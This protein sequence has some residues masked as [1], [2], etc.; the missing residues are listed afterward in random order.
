[1]HCEQARQW[2]SRFQ[3]GELAPAMHAALADHLKICTA[4]A[5]ELASLTDLRRLVQAAGEPEPP[6]D[7]WERIS[8]QLPDPARPRSRWRQ[9]GRTVVAAGVL[10]VVL[11]AGGLGLRQAFHSAQPL[12]AAAGLPPA[13]QPYLDSRQLSHVGDP[14][15]LDQ[16]ARFVSFRVPADLSLPEDYQLEDCCV[17]GDGCCDV[18]CCCF[19]GRTDQV[20]LVL[21]ADGHPVRTN[22]PPL[23]QPRI[24]GKSVR[25]VR[26]AD[27]L[28]A[29]WQANGTAVSLIGPRDLDQLVQLA[30]YVDQRLQAEP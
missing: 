28:A 17:C 15:R 25:V 20:L 5:A 30:R 6:G 1:M 13:W 16:A 26:C 21:C 11:V 3:D 9:P 19:V 23:A 24:N 8:Q 14:V 2:L 4:C 10:L 22:G 29:L 18:V 7:L 27:R 12:P